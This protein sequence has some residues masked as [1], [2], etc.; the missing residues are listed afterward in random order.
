MMV[1]I[2]M[3]HLLYVTERTLNPCLLPSQSRRGEKTENQ[4]K[5]SVA[6]Y[7]FGKIIYKIDTLGNIYNHKEN[8]LYIYEI[9]RTNIRNKM[10]YNYLWA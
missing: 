1:H 4:Q 2:I 6:I 7:C 5:V 8:Y 10:K 9:L 3:Y